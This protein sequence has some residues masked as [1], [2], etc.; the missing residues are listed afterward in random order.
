MDLRFFIRPLAGLVLVVMYFVPTRGLA[1]LNPIFSLN[2]GGFEQGS[3]LAE[4]GWE[5]I[6][7]SAAN[8][9]T[10]GANYPGATGSRC[11]YLSSDYNS[12]NPNTTL[13][14][15]A[16]IGQTVHL[17]RTVSI[18]ASDSA[19]FLQ[20]KVT[21]A[22]NSGVTQ[23][24]VHLD[25]SMLTIFS[26]NPVG[27][28]IWSV[29]SSMINSGS[30]AP[31]I[32]QVPS[33]YAGKIVRLRFEF[34]I[35]TNLSTITAS[36][37]GVA[38][39]DIGLTT[40]PFTGNTIMASAV[41]GN[42]SNPA[43]WVGGLIPSGGEDVVIPASA[44]LQADIGLQPGGKTL[45][46]QGTIN[47][48]IS[49]VG[50]PGVI[51]S[52]GSLTIAST[53]R[54]LVRERLLRIGGHFTAEQGAV[55]DVRAGGLIFDS[56]GLVN[57]Q[58][59]ITLDSMG[60]FV[61]RVM[62][63][64]NCSAPAGLRF[65]MANATTDTLRVYSSLTLGAGTANLGGHVLMDNSVASAL[66]GAVVPAL[67]TIVIQRGSLTSFPLL[68]QNCNLEVRY[69]HT[70]SLSDP[71]IAGSRNELPPNR[72]FGR[73]TIGTA[74]SYLRLID[75]IWLT[76]NVSN[77]LWLF[78]PA[79]VDSGRKVVLLNAG[80]TTGVST[81]NN[82][83]LQGKLVLTINSTSAINKRYPV[84]LN[85]IPN[86]FELRSVITTGEAKISVEAIPPSTGL[87]ATPVFPLTALSPMA[88]IKVMIDSGLVSSISQVGAYFT[89][90][91]GIAASQ[92]GSLRLGQS[93]TLQGAY[94]SIG[95][96]TAPTASPVISNTGSYASSAFYTL[97][98]EGG[99]FRRVWT[100][101]GR[102]DVWETPENWSGN[103]VP[104][105]SDNVVFAG[106]FTRVSLT[107]DYQVASLEVGP[108]STIE[109]QAGSRLRIG[110]GAGTGSLVF[111][112]LVGQGHAY[113]IRALPGSVLRVD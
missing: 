23:L 71:L 87:G 94:A 55:I 79:M 96:S 57:E 37:R 89:S 69:L 86:H 66:A 30:F 8:G 104:T 108:Q 95:P 75:D 19:I 11:V 62:A 4:N 7:G 101:G 82:G 98:L 80:A 28:S 29:S 12:T 70:A 74:F 63:S 111:G 35:L 58:R 64:L 13:V 102:T 72:R 106:P 21:S 84:G 42:W 93:S 53:G 68:G 33:V 113:G 59:V 44:I 15:A 46:V 18:P 49:V 88:R 48:N 31:V 1:Q 14:P 25:T 41:G 5:V 52:R 60:Q 105:A 67:C 50:N 112:G 38:L 103:Q 85:N 54:L 26:G 24:N 20:F 78:G 10:L 43:T 83:L 3:T 76:D 92:I 45:L 47:G 77:T 99:E 39:D 110:Q 17:F 9:W 65:Q 51:S 22:I 56:T 109:L 90:A 16:S 40:R 81:A 2:E 27:T 91:D 32:L 73:L 97:A 34:R 61:N 6:N 107:G 100:G 36:T